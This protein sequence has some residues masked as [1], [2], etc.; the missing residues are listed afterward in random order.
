MAG[1]EAAD[2]IASE[3]VAKTIG[4]KDAKDRLVGALDDRFGEQAAKYNELLENPEQIKQILSEGAAKVRPIAGEHLA[5][6]RAII[7]V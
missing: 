1:Q 6:L 7:G 5:R 3:L 2:A 4:W